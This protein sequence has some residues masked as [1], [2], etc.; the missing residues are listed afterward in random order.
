MP[1]FACGNKTEKYDEE[2]ETSLTRFEEENEGQEIDNSKISKDI[3]SETNKFNKYL[4]DINPV[5]AENFEL[6]EMVGSGSE[7]YVYKTIYKRNKKVIVC[8]MIYK[9]EEEDMNINKKELDIG[10]KLKN[11]NI[12]NFLGSLTI[13]KNELYFIAMEYDKFGNLRNFQRNYLKRNILSEQL[14]CYISYCILNGL[15]YIHMC[16]IAHMD[17]KPQNITVDDYLCF[18]IIDFSISIDYSKIDEIKLPTI[19]T[20]FYMSPEVLSN[21]TIKAKD[22]NKVD[23]YS[24]GVILYNLAF[25]DYPYNLSH[26]ESEDYDKIAEKIKSNWEIKNEDNTYSELFIDFLKKL[27][28][29]D[30]DKRMNIN[31]ALNHTWAKGAKILL[32]EKEKVFQ[33]SNFLLYLLTDHFKS[34]NDYVK[35]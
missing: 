24:L 27:L 34:F 14:I 2:K 5:L 19:G 3:I 16:K 18:K 29:K 33:C 13:R 30:I 22:L 6:Q 32:D 15:K 20:N 17:L 10:M 26:E 11:K 1:R 23:L 31:Q 28:E 25:G 12:T 8:K 9:Q 4:R 21:K 35:K 7:S